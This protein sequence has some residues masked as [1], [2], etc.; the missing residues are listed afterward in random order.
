MLSG[1]GIGERLSKGQWTNDGGSFTEAPGADPRPKPLDQPLHSCLPGRR[2]RRARLLQ[3]GRRGSPWP[4]IE[5]VGRMGPDE[6]IATHGPFGE[7]GKPM[8]LDDLPTTRAILRR[9]AGQP[10]FRIRTANG[11]ERE[12]ASSAFPIVASEEGS[13]GAMIMSGPRRSSRTEETSEGKE[14]GSARLGSGPGAGDQSLRRQHVIRPA[15]CWTAASSCCSTQEPGSGTWGWALPRR[16]GS[17]SCSP[18]SIS[19]TSR[20]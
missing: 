10:T 14:L 12:I 5:D 6:W 3:R 17:T 19:T 18:T 9:T 15:R 1:N 20:A 11:G 7:D 8:A 4:P 16:R 13:S 2:A